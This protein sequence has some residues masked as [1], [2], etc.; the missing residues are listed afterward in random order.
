MSKGTYIAC[1]MMFRGD[2][3]YKDIFSAINN[4]KNKTLKFVDWC[5]TGFKIGVS[6][7]LP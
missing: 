7:K 6:N 1:S 5:P 4:V 2:I 3:V